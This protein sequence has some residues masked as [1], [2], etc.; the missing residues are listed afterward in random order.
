M[1]KLLFI[2]IETRSPKPLPKIG[3]WAY[4]E[5]AIIT[6]CAYA[7]EN[8]GVKLWDCTKTSL[9]PSDLLAY[10]QDPEIIC[11]AHNSFFERVLFKKALNIDIPIHR[12]ICTSV[13]ARVNGLPSSLKNACLALRFPEHLTKMDEGK[14]LIARF[15]SGSIDTSPYDFKKLNHRHAWGLFGEYCKRDVEATRELYKRLNPLSKS[16]RNLWLLDQMINDR[17]YMIDLELVTKLQNLISTERER[18]D[19]EMNILTNG[20]VHS[21]RRTELLNKYLFLMEGVDLPDMSEDTIKTTLA[22]VHITE[23]AKAILANR[24]ASSQSAILKLNTLSKAVNSD[25]RLRGTL[26]FYGASRTGRWSGCVFQP[27]NLPRQQRSVSELEQ[28][29]QTLLSDGTIKDPLSFASDCVRSCIIASNGK[30]LVVADLAGIEARVLAWIAGEQWKLDAFRQEEDV[31]VTSYAKAFNVSIASVTKEQRAIGKVMELALGYQGGA[32]V[33]QTMASNLGLDLQRF[34]EN[35]RKTATIEDWEQAETRCIWMQ[36]TYPEYAVED[37]FI[38]TA[39]E[40][41]KTAW[42]TKHK[43]VVQL[44][45][46]CEEGFDCV[47][48]E[49]RSIVAR[50]ANCVPRLVMKKQNQNVIITLPSQRNLVYADVKHDRSYLNS[51]T[52]QLIR[53]RTYGGKLTENI[54]QAVSRDILIQGMINATQAGYPIV[55]TV[56]DEI[57]CEVPDTSEYNIQTLCNLMIQPPIWAQSLPLKAE[58]YEAKRYRK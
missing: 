10:L 16:E 22:Q 45:K 39:C 17:G 35:V 37:L 51:A 42:R 3:V 43:Q 9:I 40:L 56:H 58:G 7:F 4:A 5:E 47:V 19:E 15:C 41:V 46:D 14:A 44:W 13:L 18:L 11:V 6:L 52:S 29:I 54:V 38:G 12:W 25:G 33:F 24:L 31:Y 32:K 50:R 53:E 48:K 34:S 8:E 30:K 28:D 21:A 23:N 20:I 27:Q 57:V 1:L 36:E 49:G 26:Q 55:L 2:D